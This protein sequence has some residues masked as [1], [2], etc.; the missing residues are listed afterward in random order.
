MTPFTAVFNPG[1]PV[2]LKLGL[3]NDFKENG[4]YVPFMG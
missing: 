2:Q 3:P 1:Q 4:Q